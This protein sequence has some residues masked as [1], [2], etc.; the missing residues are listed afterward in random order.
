MHI[1]QQLVRFNQVLITKEI[2]NKVLKVLSVRKPLLVSTNCCLVSVNRVLPSK[3]HTEIK[4]EINW[5][6]TETETETD[7]KKLRH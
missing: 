6:E 1:N 7:H 2:N 3:N 4:R 5:A